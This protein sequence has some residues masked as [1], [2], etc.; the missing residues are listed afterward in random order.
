MGLTVSQTSKIMEHHQCIQNLIYT[1]PTR[2]VKHYESDHGYIITTT[3]DPYP[4][5][6]LKLFETTIEEYADAITTLNNIAYLKDDY[7]LNV[8][9]TLA[10]A[11]TFESRATPIVKNFYNQPLLIA[12]EN[13]VKHL[14]ENLQRQMTIFLTECAMQHGLYSHHIRCLRVDIWRTSAQPHIEECWAINHCS[15]MRREH[16]HWI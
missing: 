16:W 5:A 8:N 13:P 7:S 3:W 11:P 15:H 14:S 4:T 1:Y 10:L 6:M 2:F 12:G 9:M